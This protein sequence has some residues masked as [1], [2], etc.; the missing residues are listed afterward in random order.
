MP[1]ACPFVSLRF[2][3]FKPRTFDGDALPGG[4]GAH[5]EKPARLD[6]LLDYV[7]M[8]SKRIQRN[9]DMRAGPKDE[10]VV[11]TSPSIKG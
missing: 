7:G 8:V 6:D 11:R 4:F 9:A 1:S 5:D 3:R 10:P 2:P